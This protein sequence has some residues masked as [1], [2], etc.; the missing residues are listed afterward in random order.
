MHRRY[1]FAILAF[2]VCVGCGGGGVTRRPG[3][4][5]ADGSPP[6]ADAAPSKPDSILPNNDAFVPDAPTGSD[7]GDACSSPDAGPRCGN[8]ILEDG[9]LCDDGN[10]R[11][12]DGC[13]GLCRK[14]PNYTCPTPGQPC[15]P[16][17]ICGD[18]K[19]SSTEACEDGNTRDGD[20]C[21][22]TC[23]LEASCGDAGADAD[24]GAV[25]V[26]GDGMLTSGETC[27]D[28]AATSGDG[29]SASCQIEVDWICPTPGKPCVLD[30]Y[31]GDGKLNTAGGE[32]CDDGNTS[33]GDGCTA[34][35]VKEPFY[36][37]PVPGQKCV[38]TVVCGDG[39]VVGDEACD[40]GR[41]TAGDGCAADCKQVEPG[42][43]CPTAEGVG[44]ACRPAT[45]GTCGDAIL[46][47]G[48]ACD[49]GNSDAS[50]GCSAACQ[51]DPG[52]RCLEVGRRC[53]LV[54][55]CGDGILG[56]ADGEQC[57]DGNAL[58]DDGCSSTCRLEANYVC[59]T[60]GQKCQST[61]VCGD[62]EV[63][64]P[65]ECDDGNT[66]TGDGCS[67]L[68]LTEAGWTCPPRSVCRPAKCGDGI[69][70]GAETCDDGNAADKDGCSSECRLESPGPTE[71]DGWL[72]TTPGEPCTRTKCG[73]G[74]PEG[75]E[76]CD[77]G[78]NDMGDGCTPFCRKEPSCPVTGGA[79]Q[80]A[81]GDGLLLPVDI[82]AGQECDDGN[83]LSG[84]GC[85]STCKIEGGYACDSAKVAQDP[86]ILPVTYRDFKATTEEGGHPDFES[87]N[88]GVQQ[89][90]QGIAS[91][92]LGADGK[93]A[94]GTR[95]QSDTSPTLTTTTAM[96]YTTGTAADWFA[97]WY[98]DS[99]YCRSQ[100]DYLTFANP[101]PGVYVY[102]NVAFFPLDDKPWG[103]TYND[104][105]GAAHNFHFTSEVRYWFEYRGGE[106]LEFIGDDDVWV[107]INKKL[108]VDLGGVHG[109]YIGRVN[110]D[111]ANGTGVVHDMEPAQNKT[112]D[113]CRTRLGLSTDGDTRTVD[114]G[115][116]KGSVYEIVVFQAE[117]HTTDSHY[118]LTLSNF[119]ATRSSCH[120][121][122]GDGVVT[123]D[124]I[125][126]LGT[127]ENTGEYGGCNEDCT[128]APYCGDG[129]VNG[130]AGLEQCDQGTLNGT[131]AASCDRNCRNKCGNGVRDEGE[132]CDDGVNDGSYGTCMPSCK[133]AAY[134]GDGI[135]NGDEQ[136]DLGVNNQV[137][138]YGVDQCT[139]SCTRAPYCGDGFVQTAF[140][141]E[142]DGG[143][144]CK[145]DCK[146][147]D[148]P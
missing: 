119:A 57:D 123:S 47:A 91:S 111:A 101:S 136:C 1:G 61:V 140:G 16:D 49:D 42:Y 103:L 105:A 11:P 58:S 6:I 48:E 78:N 67:P 148:I 15:I 96:V 65:E 71:A 5:D 21:S 98:K 84:D 54:A 82:A 79:C 109:A 74:I 138:P 124:E 39:K 143:V 113:T 118:K 107:Y 133:L 106:T 66:R 131:R 147:G 53:R 87:V 117:R 24:C 55:V 34:S 112:T 7:C 29:C 129:R 77:D 22:S 128:R 90:Q 3:A 19:L 126:D 145:S 8:G 51:I 132:E 60:P 32:Q 104:T 35:C 4:P 41:T 94:P 38:S 23:Q 72:C 31:C 115:L 120:T 28:G 80:T 134:C 97:L 86:M 110:L 114:L 43:N 59:P 139:K 141:E 36:D 33:S 73:D 102:D 13:S 25:P 144:L 46:G 12:G 52:Y 30:S 68:C 75:S 10:S 135:R 26:C 17:P 70:V 56:L 125:C 64:G 122:C 137:S 93:P 69:R 14:D 88:T 130:P 92:T 27:D 127:A 20:G 40:D 45:Q 62:G 2:G 44:G 89:C 116:A 37:C 142:C 18:G 50:D 100:R 121:V 81:C 76:Q 85:S 146:R 63:A 95:N 99:S 9:E 83:T 108:A